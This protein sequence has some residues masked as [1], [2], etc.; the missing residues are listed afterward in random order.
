MTNDEFIEMVERE[1]EL[2]KEEL[3]GWINRYFDGAEIPEEV[4]TKIL[5][6]AELYLQSKLP[7]APEGYF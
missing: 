3:I 6:M 7:P 4:M 5:H 1:Q 2:T